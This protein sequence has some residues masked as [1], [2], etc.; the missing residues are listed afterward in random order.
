MKRER[1]LSV[2]GQVI[3]GVVLLAWVAG[4]VLYLRTD[5]PPSRQ[6]F[7]GEVSSLINWEVFST[8]GVTETAYSITLSQ[9]EPPPLEAE[10]S[11]T[12]DGKA[13]YYVLDR[14]RANCQAYGY[15]EALYQT[16]TE[17]GGWVIADNKKLFLSSEPVPNSDKMVIKIRAFYRP[18]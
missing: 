14:A 11:I 10:Y 2:R 13:A 6:Q 18:R 4:V 17:V 16:P 15:T 12:M 3:A 8:G 9:Q 5:K 1:L 7:V